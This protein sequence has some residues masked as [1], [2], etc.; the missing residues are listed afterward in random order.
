VQS[1]LSTA[2]TVQ[3]FQL[4]ETKY[5]KRLR[6]GGVK[7]TLPAV[8][9]SNRYVVCLKWGTKYSPEYV[10]NL[11]NMVKRNL[12]LEY[13]FVCFT[14]DSTGIDSHIRIEPLPSL[15]VKGWWYK[16]YFLSS[17]L[18]FSG[19]V[20]FLDLDLIIFRSIDKLFT[21]QPNQNFLIIRDFNRQV[22]ANWDKMNSSVFRVTT[23][24]HDALYKDFIDNI[25]IHTRR[26]PGDQDFMY[27]NI[28]D[29]KFWPDEWMQSY[30]WEMRAR[31]ELILV[32]G[33]RTFK[34]PG[35]PTILPD[36]SIAVFH[37]EPNIHDCIDKWPHQNWR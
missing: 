33:K 34:S 20:L 7:P 17:N 15:P 12:S 6:K 9:N 16:P 28:T 35:D 3:S 11:Y 19:T 27:K 8:S 37:G 24:T 10:N 29:H 36:T 30:K 4:T 32:K 22:R 1:V 26:F 31:K 5:E 23:G 2:Q 14:E 18:P 25:Q 13:E 21:Y